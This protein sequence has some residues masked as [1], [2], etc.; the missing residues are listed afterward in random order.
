MSPMFSLKEFRWTSRAD[1]CRAISATQ[2]SEAVSSP[3]TGGSSGDADPR[4]RF[5]R[6]S[7]H[8]LSAP[9][10]EE[11]VPFLTQV[12]ACSREHCTSRDAAYRALCRMKPQLDPEWWIEWVD[13]VREDDPHG[14]DFAG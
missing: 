2:K 13:S 9:A 7:I 11:A 4:A 6:K 8:L 12:L 3:G 5:R 14:L 1:L 10:G